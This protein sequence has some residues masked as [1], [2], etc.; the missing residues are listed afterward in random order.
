[1][2][3]AENKIVIIRFFVC[4]FKIHLISLKN[5][6]HPLF[7]QRLYQ[8]IY[9]SCRLAKENKSIKRIL[10]SRLEKVFVCLPL[11]KTVTSIK[12]RKLILLDITIYDL[13]DLKITICISAKSKLKIFTNINL[14]IL[15]T[16]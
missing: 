11:P 6:H 12:H 16:C 3:Q 8:I 2:R 5:I 9:L 14:F 15:P 10:A 7:E 4:E 13:A 1:M